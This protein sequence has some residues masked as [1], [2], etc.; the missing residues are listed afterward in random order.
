M[1]ENIP[2]STRAKSSDTEYIFIIYPYL[3]T[4]SIF[5]SKKFRH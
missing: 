3:K 2:N 1:I 5:L 4:L